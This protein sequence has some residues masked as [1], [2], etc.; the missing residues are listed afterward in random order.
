MISIVVAFAGN[1][2]IGRDGRLPWHLPTDMRRFR[3]LTT[4]RAVI[5]GRRTFESL[6]EAHRP[7]PNR[8]NLVLSSDPDCRADGAEVCPDLP[9]ALDA[10]DGDCF[11]I[12]GAVAY[13]DALSIAER[14]YATEIEGELDG[15]AFFPALAEAEWRCIEQS[16][17]IVENQHGFTFRVYE[18]A[19][20]TAV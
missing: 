12:G 17:R 18:R 20:A 10:C 11:V 8:R 15:D 2:V 16:E 5:M 7:L 13:R 1:G 14:V 3:E 4:G 9:S 6:P 19:T